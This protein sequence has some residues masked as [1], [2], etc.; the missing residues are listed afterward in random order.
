[1]RSRSSPQT[2]KASPVP[3]KV[4]VLGHIR[5]LIRTGKLPLGGRISDKRIA[6]ELGISR[7]PV[8]EALV[9]LQSEGLVTS[10]PQSGTFVIDLNTDG[11]HQI[12]GARAVLETGALRL[13][14]EKFAPDLR[15]LKLLVGRAAAA[16]D[17]G[18]LALCD[19][20]DSE[21]HE[22]LVAMSGNEHIIKAYTGISDLLRALRHRMPR[23]EQRIAR[24]IKQHRKILDLIAAGSIEKAAAELT[25]HVN[26][27][28]RLLNAIEGKDRGGD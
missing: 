12:C 20:L 22:T 14:A 10:R 26:N 8:R 13:T 19:R 24:A 2:A 17:N 15:I 27:V 16:L 23:N 21:F 3:G 9:Q 25:G 7:T 5:E 28:E 4:I 11:I 18:S 1:M 6:L